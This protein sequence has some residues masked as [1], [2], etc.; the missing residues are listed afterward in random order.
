[1]RHLNRPRT[2]CFVALCW[3]SV[4]LGCGPQVSWREMRTEVPDLRLQMPCRPNVQQRNLSLAGQSVKMTML[5][6]DVAE[7]TFALAFADMGDP[8]R[9]DLGMASLSSSFADAI[10]GQPQGGLEAWDVQGATPQPGSGRR[11]FAGHLGHDQPIQAEMGV[12]ARGTYVLR[13]TVTAS[14]LREEQL[15]PFFEGVRFSIGTVR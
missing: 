14:Q 1:M 10:R 4:L 15:A 8:G 6:C 12:L 3:V 13:W 5:V 7:T 9:V 11:R 2:F